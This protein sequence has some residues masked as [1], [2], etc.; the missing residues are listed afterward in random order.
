MET[1]VLNNKVEKIVI[2]KVGDQWKVKCL[3]AE[4]IEKEK[5]PKPE[6]VRQR[7]QSYQDA[8]DEL[9]MEDF[10]RTNL[11]PCEIARRELEMIALA[12]NDLWLPDWTNT[13]E[14]KWYPWFWVTKN[15][16]ANVNE[17]GLASD[18]SNA[19]LAC[20]DTAYAP[21]SA[22]ADFGARLCFKN[23]ALAEYAGKKFVYLYEQM[24]YDR[25]VPVR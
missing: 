1:I 12:L 15:E 22:Y 24:F 8:L 11:R 6:D 14:N 17:G 9:Q 23:E 21:S 19:G 2:D 20:S 7:V 5:R 13:R 18:A 3:N 10:D 25:L 4:D 16:S